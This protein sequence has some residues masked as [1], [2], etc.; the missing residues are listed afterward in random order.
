M[1]GFGAQVSVAVAVPVAA[2]LRGPGHST[3]RSG[4]Q[5]IVGAAES[6]VQM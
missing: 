5:L 6:S 2:G 1:I 4:G 3:V